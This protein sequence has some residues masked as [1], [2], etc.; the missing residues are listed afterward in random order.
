MFSWIQKVVAPATI[1]NCNP[2][3]KKAILFTLRKENTNF[4]SQFRDPRNFWDH[5]GNGAIHPIIALSVFSV[6]LSVKT[7]LLARSLNHKQFTFISSSSSFHHD[8]VSRFFLFLI[9][10]CLVVR[11]KI[12]INMCGLLLVFCRVVVDLSKEVVVDVSSN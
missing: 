11:K 5:P 8:V 7:S 2:S 1:S 6:S 10:C 9:V 3:L 4:F 12:I